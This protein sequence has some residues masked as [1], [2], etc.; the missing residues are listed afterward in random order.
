MQMIMNEFG[1]QDVRAYFV[2]EP[3]LGGDNQQAARQS[4]LRYQA[5]NSVYFWTPTRK[6]SDEVASI[7]GLA[8]GRPAWDMYFL[9]PK[10][11]V[12]DRVFPAPRYWQRQLD[13]IQG[14]TFNP[15]ILRARIKDALK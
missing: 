8:A 9:Y 12:W 5:P 6:L 2:W 14:D 10:G 15:Q 11:V 1:D 3:I 4:T 13:V 7:L